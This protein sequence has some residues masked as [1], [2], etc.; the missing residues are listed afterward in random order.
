MQ[1][2]VLPPLADHSILRLTASSRLGEQACRR[3]SD[4][5]PQCLLA[6]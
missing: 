6:L 1:M 3:Q 5:H 4:V 2:G